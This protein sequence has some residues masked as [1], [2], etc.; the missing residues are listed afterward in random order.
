[1]PSS[2]SESDLPL[3]MRR[4]RLR[5]VSTRRRPPHQHFGDGRGR[6]RDSQK[7]VDSTMQPSPRRLEARLDIG[8]GRWRA[9]W[10]N[11]AVDGLAR[12]HVPRRGELKPF[13]AFTPIRGT[14]RVYGRCRVCRALRAREK[15]G[16]LQPVSAARPVGL[17]LSPT[18]RQPAHD[19]RRR[20][21]AEAASQSSP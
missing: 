11:A 20:R 3:L 12:A 5:A 10:F 6:W 17:D 4:L 15:E 13:D 19:D 18:C 16:T 21:A 2:N 1:M 14:S 8:S 7:G 9:P